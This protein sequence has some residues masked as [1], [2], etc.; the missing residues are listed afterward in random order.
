VPSKKY[1]GLG[2][3]LGVGVLLF[4]L[5]PS[6]A[7]LYTDWL[8]FLEV[9]HEQVFLRTLNS[10][11]TLGA[12]AFVL[13]FG[14]LYVNIRIAQREL[15]QR[16][17]TVFGPQGPRT[18]AIDMRSLRPLF[19]AGAAI[20][21][22]FVAL[23]ASGRWDTWLMARNAVPFG[24]VDPVLG[25]DISFYL[26]QLPLL[27]FLHG[28]V[29]IT[30]VLGAIAA[31]LVYF[32]G[33]SI[34]L[35]PQRGL[36]VSDNARRHLSVIGVLVLVTLAFRAWL[37]IPATLTT[38]SGIIHGASFVDVYATIPT[39]W[40]L[41]VVSLIG[42]GLIAYQITVSRRWPF[43]AAVALYV[44][45]SILG[46]LYAFALQRLYVAPNE[47]VRELPFIQHSIAATRSAF[48]LDSVEE[49][50]I[51]GDATLTLA[52]I[53]RNAATLDNVPLWNDQPLLDTFGQIQ[54]IR[55]Y[56]DFVSVDNDRYKIDGKYRQIMLSARELNSES[57]PSATWINQRLTFT[58]GYGLTLG[59]VNEVTPEGLPVLFVKDLPLQSTVDLKVTQPAIYFGERS[60]DHVFVKTATQEFDYPRGD[61]NVFG[62]YSGKGGVEVGGVFRRL[63]F[64]VRFSSPDTLFSPNLN[65]NS[66]VLMYRRIAE[67]VNR[68]APFLTYDPDPYLAISG[69]RLVWIQDAYTISQLYPYSTPSARGINYIR[70]SVK[71]TIDAYDGTIRFH[72]ID[73]KDPIAATIARVFPGLFEPLSAMPE[74]LRTRLRYPQGIFSLQA[75]MF[76]TFHMTNPSTFYNREDQWDVP[77]LEQG[78]EGAR[79]MQPYY[80]IMK[81]PGEADAEYIQMLPYTPR[82]K[83]N[84][85]A[86]MAARSDGEHYG[87]LVV[88]QFPKQ[89][90]IFGPRQ[91]AAR[92]SQDQ[93]I[94]PQITLWN[95]Q[96]SEVIQG[97]LL[98]IPIEESLLYIRPLY[99]R[100]AGGRIPELKRV[101]VAYQNHIVMEE[102]LNEALERLFPAS[103]AAQRLT[104][105]PQPSQP[106][107]PVQPGS[108]AAPSGGGGAALEAQQH[109]ERAIE[110][111]RAGD[112]AR[113]GE[114][115]RQLG[116]T[117]KRLN[118]PPPAARPP[119]APAPAG[120]P[121]PR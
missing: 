82:Q 103:G 12:A 1:L 50:S 34:M 90:V 10:R 101:V 41:V 93:V 102:T 100:A 95:Q 64:A 105:A 5:L 2:L 71:I 16:E 39:Q 89:T 35:D 9:G 21:A 60:N 15:R 104:T 91:I 45:V 85:A 54:E 20:V 86:W 110:A 13:V 115:I 75:A 83:D 37:G 19:H 87:K 112:W 72:L 46:N 42:A 88:F 47:Q 96:G 84:L 53:T 30:L 3:L 18:I 6:F 11:V 48:A 36:V 69:G 14:V 97:N 107:R 24:K 68:I 77:S 119:A 79:P 43:V 56:Y 70:N 25:Y 76:A 59:P 98:V 106:Q 66:R 27:H 116:E 81:L 99:L 108:A 121:P 33:L 118:A 38:Q 29:F 74:D 31:G 109:Y 55:T 67:R 22:F 94:A 40:V 111:Q 65:E 51:S 52:D 23:Y 117:L 58:H 114:E 61:A 7:T 8:W 32:A 49:R 113:Y 62:T 57:L 92:I 4:V 28:F 44:G 17:F 80:T 26:F 73:T 120:S 63:L 78:R